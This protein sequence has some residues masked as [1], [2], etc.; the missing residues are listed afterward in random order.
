VR[1]CLIA[2]VA[3]SPP[4]FTARR[5]PTT[6]QSVVVR[7]VQVSPAPGATPYSIWLEPGFPLP[8]TV[9]SWVPVHLDSPVAIAGWVPSSARG[10]RF[11]RSPDPAPVT[12]PSEIDFVYEL[13]VPGSRIIAGFAA[14]RLP[15]LQG[16]PGSWA[17]VDVTVGHVHIVGWAV[18]RER[19]V[20]VFD[21]DDDVIEGD[22]GHAAKCGRCDPD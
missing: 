14:D 13:P 2:L 7:E 8:S 9:A 6:F 19:K 16:L 20:K 22:H 18:V 21:F 10:V 12:P 11:A 17:P 1:W 3:C 15:F 4:A 5:W